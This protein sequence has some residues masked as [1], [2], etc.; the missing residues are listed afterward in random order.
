MGTA[1]TIAPHSL[2]SMET[3]CPIKE[4]KAIH[5]F[6]FRTHT[7][8]LGTYHVF[9]ILLEWITWRNVLHLDHISGVRVA[10]YR[11]R[12][13][14][15]VDHWTLIGERNP[16]DPQMFYEVEQP[17]IIQKGDFVVGWFSFFCNH[18]YLYIKSYIGNF[19][20]RR[21]LVKWTLLKETELLVQGKV[22]H[23]WVITDY[24]TP[25]VLH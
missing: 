24:K 23:Y 21:L 15:N 10:G 13:K 4:D 22:P 5:P 3:S 19:S 12:R 17:I 25:L 14:N 9:C 16:M 7:H 11:V 6:A 2:E 1:G 20:C 8:E 18:N